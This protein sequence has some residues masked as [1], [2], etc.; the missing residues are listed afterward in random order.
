MIK[1]LSQESVITAIPPS[2]LLRLVVASP[3]HRHCLSTLQLVVL[4]VASPL[5]ATLSLNELAGSTLPL[6]MPPSR[7]TQLVVTS[8]L[9]AA[10]IAHRN[11]QILKFLAGSL[12]ASG[13]KKSVSRPDRLPARFWKKSRGRTNW[14]LVGFNAFL[15]RSH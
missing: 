10:T 4:V 8:P 11:C 3:R 5:V 9:V 7:L 6:I 14:K 13:Q 2:C 12:A 15:D 1:T